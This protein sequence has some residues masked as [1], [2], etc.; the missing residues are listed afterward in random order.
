MKT[1][2]HLFR[3]F[4]A[5]TALRD[6]RRQ[7]V[8]A[9]SLVEVTLA[10]GIVTFVLVAVIGVMP[11]ALSSGRQSFDQNRAAAVANT[12]F[13]SFR[14]QPFSGV[15]YVDS[16]FN[17]EDGATTTSGDPTLLNLNSLGTTSAPVQ[18]YASFLDTATP[19]NSGNTDT[20]GQQRRLC[21]TNVNSA[22]PSGSSS[23]LVTLRF[24]NQPAGMAISP[25]TASATA[26]SSSTAQA[27]QI[28]M[29]ISPVQAKTTAALAQTGTKYQFVSTIANRL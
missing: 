7:A 13:S 5:L 23:Y 28:E 1:T 22:L 25:A 27:N 12:L 21:F 4:R 18:F 20:F 14:S 24:N 10:L 15:G 26:G 16:Q 29:I 8:R 11:A 9:F 3:S 19:N 2:F 17:S 6:Q